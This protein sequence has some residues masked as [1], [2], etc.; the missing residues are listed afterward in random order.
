LRNRRVAMAVSGR[1]TQQ[2]R[3]HS[4]LF[5]PRAGLR[6][7]HT[8]RHRRIDLSLMAPT[9]PKRFRRKPSHF[10]TSLT[11]IH[12]LNRVCPS[13]GHFAHINLA[14]SSR[15][16]RPVIKG[17]RDRTH[18]VPDR[19]PRP[20]S[21]VAGRAAS[22]PT[23]CGNDAPACQ[24]RE[25]TC[26]SNVRVSENLSIGTRSRTQNAQKELLSCRTSCVG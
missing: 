23:H 14:G 20:F 7:S 15:L 5:E 9:C 4:G 8:P 25:T 10:Q 26:T 21:L 13:T 18:R 3:E 1:K 24:G 6:S 12:C 19:S 22:C 2:I 16:R 17:T 11:F